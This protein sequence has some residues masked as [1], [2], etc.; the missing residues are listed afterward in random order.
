MIRL[1][2]KDLKGAGEH[3]ARALAITPASK[4]ALLNLAW[5]ARQQRDFVAGNEYFDRLI[6]FGLHDREI[7]LAY[8]AFLEQ[9]EAVAPALAIYRQAL[10]LTEEQKEKVMALRIKER[11]RLLSSYQE[12]PVEKVKKATGL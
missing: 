2:K 5:L 9:Q 1:R 3:F 11:M 10:N 12:E 6:A 7:L 4:T 8:A